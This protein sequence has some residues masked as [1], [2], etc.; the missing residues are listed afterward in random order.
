[1]PQRNERED[2]GVID[3]RHQGCFPG[4]GTGSSEW[5]VD[6]AD[7]PAIVTSV[8]TSPE[9]DGG[10]VVREA[11]DHVFGGIDPVNQGPEP[12]KSPG[13]EELEPEDVEVEVR[14]KRELGG[15]IVRPVGVAFRDSHTI[16]EVEEEL[17]CEETK[18]E[19]DTV[20]D[21]ARSLDTGR[22]VLHLRD[23]VVERYDWTS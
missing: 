4:A 12:E 23:V 14:E 10:R 6:V 17:H 19:S 15:A 9:R 13:Q 20:L 3:D 18:D 2:G 5:D 7:Q 21:G 8:P 1:M 22:W 16:V 11:P